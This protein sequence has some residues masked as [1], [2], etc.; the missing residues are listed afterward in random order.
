MAGKRFEVHA[1]V[2]GSKKP[3]DWHDHETDDPNEATALHARYLRL[4]YY[5]VQTR[6]HNDG[7]TQEF[8]D[9]LNAIPTPPPPQIGEGDA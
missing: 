3:S 9:R 1:H 7:S 8:V 2:P 6:D 5:L 4:G